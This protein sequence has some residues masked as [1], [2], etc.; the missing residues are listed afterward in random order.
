VDA[1]GGQQLSPDQLL[2]TATVI[3]WALF[4]GQAIFLGVVLMIN[5]GKE[6][7]PAMIWSLLVPGFAFMQ[8]IVAGLMRAVMRGR[9]KSI[10][11]DDQAMRSQAILS[12]LLVPWAV[13]EGASLFSIVIFMITATNWPGLI[14]AGGIMA[15]FLTMCPTKKSLLTL[16]QL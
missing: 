15:L 13:L 4:L 11:P 16:Y 8:I 2:R 9:I 6:P 3:F 5:Q 1:A 14:V 12:A 7:K 10:S